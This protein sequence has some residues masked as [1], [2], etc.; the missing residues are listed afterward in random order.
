VKTPRGLSLFDGL[1]VWLA[2]FLFPFAFPAQGVLF[3]HTADTNFN[4]TPP[5]RAF[6][7]SGWQ[8]EGEWIGFNGT[9]ISSNCFITAQ[10]IGGAVGQVFTFQN[11]QYTTVTN[12]DDPNTD[13]R[14]WRVSGQ[15]PIYA[16]LYT[17]SNEVGKALIVIGRGTQRGD[18]V[19]L[20]NRLRGWQ[21]GVHDYVQRWGANRVN[22]IATGGQ[23]QGEFLRA[24]FNAGAGRNQAALSGG[25]SGGAVFIKDG[26]FYKLAGINY[27]VDGPYNTNSSGTGFYGSL[28]NQR[29]FYVEPTPGT[30][31]L[32]PQHTGRIASSFYATRISARMSW[33][34]N[35]LALPAP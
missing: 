31:E 25:D 22:G 12:Y 23:G 27:G 3:F 28:F 32:F 33:I 29:G 1:P 6:T 2:L 4:T 26:K 11:V 20:K 21:W 34:T 18:E 14:I 19:R 8:F 24:S 35:V 5:T 7:N 16:P 30:W 9:V 17:R 15:F 13:L 10:H